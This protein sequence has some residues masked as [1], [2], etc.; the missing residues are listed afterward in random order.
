MDTKNNNIE[1]KEIREFIYYLFSAGKILINGNEKNVSLPKSEF[2]LLGL[3]LK[4]KRENDLEGILPSHISEKTKL[5]RPA[6]TQTLNSL[7]KKN[8]IKRVMEKNDSRKYKVQ[9]TNEGIQAFEESLE[10][11][12]EGLST[13]LNELGKEKVLQLTEIF[14]DIV[15]IKKNI[16]KGKDIND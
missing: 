5:S 13:I 15:V 2:F 16:K 1:R 8:Y 6:V 10:Q 3:L 4:E 7:E 11:R 9:L 14:K 12:I